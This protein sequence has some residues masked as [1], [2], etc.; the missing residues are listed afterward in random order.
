LRRLG[1]RYTIGGADGSAYLLAHG[2]GVPV[3]GAVT[4]VTLP[5]PG[6]YRVLVR[7]RDWVWL[8]AP[9]QFR[10]VVNGNELE[11]VFG[12]ATPEWAWQEGAP[13]DVAGVSIT[14]ALR[15]LTGFGARCD[16]ILFVKGDEF[17]PPNDLD[18]LARFRQ[19][20]L[21]LGEPADAG[22][23]DLVVVGG[24]NVI[25]P[26]YGEHSAYS[27]GYLVRVARH[28]RAF[29]GSNTSLHDH[30]AKSGVVHVG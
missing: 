3:E 11:T 22:E 7:T 8:H 18:A 9:G 2:L 28:N 17:Q 26:M 13:I 16:A 30:P 20:A 6:T 14:L 15:D 4:K 19:E 27:C 23:Y 25:I 5:E 21:G 10:L 1:D 29:Y 24:N 12:N